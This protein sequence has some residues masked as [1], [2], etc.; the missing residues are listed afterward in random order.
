MAR[1][2]ARCLHC[3]CMVGAQNLAEQGATHVVVV[4]SGHGEGE[5][6]DRADIGLTDDQVDLVSRIRVAMDGMQQDGKVHA[7]RPRITLVLVSGG[8]TSTERVDAMVDATIWVGKPGMQAG[9]G[10]AKLLYGDEDFS[11]RLSVTVYKEAW[12]KVSNFLS[13]AISGNLTNRPRG[14]RYNT[15]SAVVQYPF[16]TGLSY[17]RYSTKFRRAEYSVSHARINGRTVVFCPA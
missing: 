14:Y 11:G 3:S 9:T 6:H 15:D 4:T 8:A 10:L 1:S 17:M 12:T 5:S 2:G 13:N 7:L 16:G